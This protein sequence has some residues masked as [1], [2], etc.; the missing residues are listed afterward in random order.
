M[1][2]TKKSAISS[3]SKKS[4]KKP[5]KKATGPVPASKL[6]TTINLGGIGQN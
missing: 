4:T 5:S 6:K 2:I 1:A 3:T